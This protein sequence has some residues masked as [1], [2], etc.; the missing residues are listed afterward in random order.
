VKITL[1]S[2]NHEL[3]W[4]DPTGG[5]R[6]ILSELLAR[7]EIEL[8]AEEACGLPTTVAQRLTYKLNKP[9]IEIDMSIPER[10]LAGIHQA[11]MDRRSA[12]IDPFSNI[13]SLSLYL[14]KEDGIRETE[15]VTRILRQRVDGV[16][17]LCGFLHIEPFTQKLGKFGCTVEHVNLVEQE[18]F[19]RLYGTYRII[20]EDGKR[21]CEIRT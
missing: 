14:P 12:P 2:L 6:R 21:W 7:P 3:Q 20:E 16:V 17:C 11:L 19:R 5:L 8:V 10:K 13:G 15:W 18:W 1:L 9:W 4:K